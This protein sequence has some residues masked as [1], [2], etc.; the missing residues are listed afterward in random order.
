MPIEACAYCGKIDLC[1][2]RHQACEVCEVTVIKPALERRERFIAIPGSLRSY[3]ESWLRENG[4]LIGE[5]DERLVV[6]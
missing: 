1:S 6:R 5:P 2:L 4:L 3:P